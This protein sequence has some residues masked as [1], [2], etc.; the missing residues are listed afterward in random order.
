MSEPPDIRLE[1]FTPQDID[2]LI[3]WIDTP[4]ALLQWGGPDLVFPLTRRQIL[5]LLALAA[6]S[7]PSRIIYRIAAPATAEVIGH[8]ELGAID[9]RHRSARIARVLVAE[10]RWR[11]RGVAGAAIAELIELAFGRLGLNR[12]EL[13][14]FDFNLAAIRCYERLGF[15]REGLRREAERVGDAYWSCCVMGLLAREWTAKSRFPR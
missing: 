5:D 8:I 4:E 12:L 1:P 6:G 15:Q 2:R 13:A 14:V 11:G 10:P 3:A 9:Q 7:A